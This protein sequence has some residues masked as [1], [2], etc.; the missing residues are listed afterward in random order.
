VLAS[1][2]NSNRGEEAGDVGEEKGSPR[3][4]RTLALSDSIARISL[5]IIFCLHYSILAAHRSP[6]RM[7]ADLINV[8]SSMASVSR[9]INAFALLSLSASRSELSFNRAPHRQARVI[10]VLDPVRGERVNR[11]RCSRAKEL[12]TLSLIVAGFKWHLIR[13]Q[14]NA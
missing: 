3:R 13:R 6:S 8:S 7:I 14:T 1:Y 2:F 9:G 10:K 5:S 11:E 12:W 4:S